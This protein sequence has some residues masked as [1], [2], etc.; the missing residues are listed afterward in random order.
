[1]PHLKIR[2]ERPKF[3]S[4]KQN[5]HRAVGSNFETQHPQNKINS[6][7]IWHLLRP[8]PDTFQSL[9]S[10]PSSLL[11][12]IKRVTNIGPFVSKIKRSRPVFHLGPGSAWVHLCRVF[13]SDWQQFPPSTFK[14]LNFTI[15]Y[16]QILAKD[17]KTTKVTNFWLADYCMVL[18][19]HHP[20]IRPTLC[21]RHLLPLFH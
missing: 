4:R 17:I 16:L 1:M 15:L 18:N 5:T 21:P 14:W 10:P 3:P 9:C 7:E 2:R 8:K 20:L 19:C 13:L 11:S 6:R 12:K